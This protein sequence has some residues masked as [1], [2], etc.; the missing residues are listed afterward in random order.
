MAA[1]ARKR[2]IRLIENSNDIFV[3][4]HIRPDGDALG[5]LL[6]LLLAL[7]K[8]GA[9]VAALCTDP[10]PANYAFLPAADR[11]LS[12]P[13]DWKAGLGIVVDC[14][15]L[16]RTGAL[17]PALA[18]L[19]ALIDL[20]H[21]DTDRTFGQERLVDATAGA[22]AEIVHELIR[23]MGTPLDAEI[24][25]CLYAAILTDTGRFCYGNTTARSLRIA[26][27]LVA[28][29]ADPHYIAR[30]V[31]EERSV[32]ATH[33]L[34]VALSRLSAAEDGQIVSSVLRPEDFECTGAAPSETEGIIGH[35][36][37][38]GGTRVAIL[39]VEPDHDAVRVS[40]RS[41]GSVDVGEVAL[42]FG[43]GGHAMAAGCT[44]TG[45]VE[46]VEQSVLEAVR[47]ALGR[48]SERDAG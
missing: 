18:S 25:T 28:S 17:E 9:R 38:I 30:K 7:E 27:E 6:G 13:P 42:G 24:S 3:A 37:A 16:G 15:G 31:Y 21:H 34:G 19:P 32:P 33:L 39:F 12:L 8:T 26:A 44:V 10:V 36:R 29:G 20:D 11:I 2:A 40:L 41:D 43:G 22:A 35:L 14:D 4:T 46:V 47:L 23:D 48:P 1:R 45:S 5:S